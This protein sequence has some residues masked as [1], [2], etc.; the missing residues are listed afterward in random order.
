MP[1]TCEV[2]LVLQQPTVCSSHGPKE[3][4]ESESANVE[5]KFGNFMGFFFSLQPEPQQERKIN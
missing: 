5:F 1:L 4:Q 2:M 3:T